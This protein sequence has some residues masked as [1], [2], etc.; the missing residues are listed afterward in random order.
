MYRHDWEAAACYALGPFGAAFMLIFEVENDYVRFHAYQVRVR[1]P[2]PLVS[3][4]ETEPCR[5][6]QSVLLNLLLVLM[7]LIFHLILGNW[8]QYLLIVADFAALILMRFAPP[9][10]GN[11]SSRAN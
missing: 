7:H 8:A 3:R 11:P 2:S 10:R 1:W 5:R 9:S 4:V 6:S